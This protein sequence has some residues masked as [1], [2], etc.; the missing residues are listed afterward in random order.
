MLLKA[1]VPDEFQWEDDKKIKIQYCAA[2][3]DLVTIRRETRIDDQIVD[4][5]DGSHLI[6]DDLNTS[7]K[8]WLY[9]LQEQ[10]DVIVRIWHG[11]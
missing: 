10:F 6:A 4:W 1:Q 7:D 9:L 2:W 3:H 8:Q 11:A 5:T